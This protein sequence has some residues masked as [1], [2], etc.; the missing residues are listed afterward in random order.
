MYKYEKAEREYFILYQKHN[1][2]ERYKVSDSFLLCFYELALKHIL[3]K[4]YKQLNFEFRIIN[5]E[6]RGIE[7]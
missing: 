5:N 3:T 6:I 7:L 4:E 2:V 1:V